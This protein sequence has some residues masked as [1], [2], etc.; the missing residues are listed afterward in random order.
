[1]VTQCGPWDPGLSHSDVT[2]HLRMKRALK[3]PVWGGALGA[4]VKMSDR[5]VRHEPYSVPDQGSEEEM[6]G[7]Q[8]LRKQKHRTGRVP[9]QMNRAQLSSNC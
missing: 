2:G 8:W 6:I 4:D 9:K 1:M 5:P 7:R 3:P